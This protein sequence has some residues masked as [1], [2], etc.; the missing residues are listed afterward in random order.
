MSD[1]NKRSVK[2]RNASENFNNSFTNNWTHFN[3]DF[4]QIILLQSFE[5]P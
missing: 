1:E 2:P 3:A 5:Y 4:I